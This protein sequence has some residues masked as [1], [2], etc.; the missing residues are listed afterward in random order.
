MKTKTDTSK[1]YRKAVIQTAYIALLITLL[2]IC[3]GANRNINKI[4]AATQSRLK[5]QEYKIK[6]VYLYN[7]LLF[8]EWP[9][10]STENG[11]KNESNETITIGILGNAPF[12]DSFSEVED[13]MI[14]SKKKILKIKRLGRYTGNTELDQCDRLFISS[15]ESRNFKIILRHI[16]SLPILTVA[17]TKNFMQAGGMINMI[18]TENKIRWEI[19]RTPV[20]KANLRL[21]SQLLRNAVN[22]MGN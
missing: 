3:A 22:V 19:N 18:K 10:P 4:G 14:R 5:A 8:T 17:D 15:S 2:T 1:P 7:F 12:Y 11:S 13:R 6:A 16:D 21:S 9:K 20:K